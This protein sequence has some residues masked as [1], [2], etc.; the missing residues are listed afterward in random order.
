MGVII[1]GRGFCNVTR[2]S[3]VPVTWFE[4]ATRRLWSTGETKALLDVLGA[5]NIQHHLD[6]IIW[7][8]AI[9]QKVASSLSKLGYKRTASTL[10]LSDLCG[11]LHRHKNNKSANQA[12]TASWIGFIKRV[13][14]IT[15]TNDTA[16]S[17]S[18]WPYFVVQTCD[19][20][21]MLISH[22]D[23]GGFNLVQVWTGLNS[24]IS[25]TK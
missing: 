15:W 13:C 10:S 24:N 3:L 11:F 21:L 8:Q 18:E 19:R 6:E 23:Q 5:D 9:Y 7:N 16:H 4:M 1:K 12:N 20:P 25:L 17:Q 14:F 22:L 2:L